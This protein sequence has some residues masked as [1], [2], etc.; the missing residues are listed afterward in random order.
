MG[1]LVS[2]ANSQDG[3]RGAMPVKPVEVALSEIVTRARVFTDAGG[4]AI[5]LR[6]GDEIV[7]RASSGGIAPEVGTRMSVEGSLT[8][9]TLLKNV[10]IHIED[11]DTDKRVD[12]Q[13]CRAMNTRSFIITPIAGSSSVLGVV[14]VFAPAPNAFTRTDLAVLRT[15]AD[16]ISA[17]LGGGAFLQQAWPSSKPDEAPE[18][19][20]PGTRKTEEPPLQ[21]VRPV[22]IA[23]P[24]VESMLPEPIL[25]P[26]QK[27]A[28]PPAV[29][30]PLVI[31]RAVTRPRAIEPVAVTRE[32]ELLSIADSI[33][34][35]PTPAKPKNVVSPQKKR[36]VS[37]PSNVRPRLA[38]ERAAKVQPR[39]I[40]ARPPAEASERQKHSTAVAV[41]EP[42]EVAA[43]PIVVLHEIAWS[44][45]T[46]PEPES[47]P[48]GKIIAGVG[49]VIVVAA[50]G[51]GSMLH[52]PAET[53]PAERT[54]S[55]PIAQS[56]PAA[57]PETSKSSQPT[58]AASV[59]ATTLLTSSKKSEP[60]QQTV[61]GESRP[62]EPAIVLGQSSSPRKTVVEEAAPPQLAFAGDKLKMPETAPAAPNLLPKQVMNN[63]VPA[64]LVRQVTPRYPEMARRIR[65][66][67]KVVLQAQVLKDGSVG[68]IITL[69]GAQLLR[70]A[71]IAAV[72]QWRYKPAQLGSTPVEST[73]QVI[74]NFD[75]PQ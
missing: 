33:E 19:F 34:L 14:A 24:A 15:M 26:Q 11:S 17:A 5:A 36:P 56:A 25:S 18:S 35:E 13:T 38:E 44:G 28:A 55:Q 69:S 20:A 3:R 8:G 63:A 74:V 67:G 43:E 47:R 1:P 62:A 6:E 72:K 65:Q 46:S 75:T 37:T 45:L 41:A 73:V 57:M 31:E 7:T 39:G 59:S 54:A 21:D 60:K 61:Q 9:Q 58:G 49:V 70:D 23:A 64:E 51:V 4:A 53:G 32:I 2:S 50:I 29:A 42:E 66:T 12:A 27:D 16:Q 22:A 52:K 30:E 10:P 40:A 68:K 71:A 48:I